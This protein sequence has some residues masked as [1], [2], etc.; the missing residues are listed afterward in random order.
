MGILRSRQAAQD[1]VLYPEHTLGRSKSCLLKLSDPG[2]SALHAVVFWADEAWS[3]KDLGSRNGTFLDGRKLVPG[4]REPL[5]R[6]A[7]LQL[8]VD[9]PEFEVMDEGAPQP[10]LVA[11]DD[12]T[13]YRWIP[14]GSLAIP[15]EERPE[16]LLYLTKSGDWCLESESGVQNVE[17]HGLFTLDGRMFRLIASR[18]MPA[19]ATAEE[20]LALTEAALKFSVS[21]DEEH[22]LLTVVARGRSVSLGHR[23]HHYLLLTLARERLKPAQ[24]GVGAGSLGWVERH[25][26]ERMLRQ[27]QQHINLAVWRARRQFA[28]V[29]FADANNVV[30]RRGSE[31]RLG[32]LQIE[33]ER[34]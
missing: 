15:S 25:D 18:G 2:V 8:G 5:A 1:V 27:T 14:D 32:P 29:G 28:E 4:V 24:P 10:L 11:A 7:V 3:V 17:E 12:P 33:I 16:A 31:L 21:S 34:S 23:A 22:V 26:L 30:E 6:G 19:T 9:G 20:Q 13:F